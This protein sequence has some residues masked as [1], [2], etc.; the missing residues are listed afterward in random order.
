M[1]NQKQ[2]CY[3]RCLRQVEIM[4][5]RFESRNCMIVRSVSLVVAAATAM[6]LGGVTNAQA[7]E[8]SSSRAP[9]TELFFEDF[10]GNKG[11]DRF[12]WGVYHRNAGWQIIGQPIHSTG[13]ANAFHGGSWTG[14]HNLD[15]GPPSTQ[16][17][18]RSD[19]LSGANF[20]FHLRELVYLCRDH[21]MTS[22]GDVDG[23][24]V[25][26]FS[27][28]QTFDSVG[29]VRFNVNLTDLGPRKWIK[30]GVVSEATYNSLGKGG[31]YD[32]NNA[33]GHVRSEVSA[34]GLSSS[35]QDAGALY[36]AWSGGASAGYPGG[37]KIGSGRARFSVNPTPRNKKLR[38]QVSLKD[39]GNGTVTFTVANAH[40]TDYASFPKCPCR[41]VFYDHNYTPEKSENGP[42]IGFTWHWDNIRVLSAGDQKG[43]DKRASNR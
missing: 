15:C 7:R 26:W 17:P 25:I 6:A 31:V 37:M 38:H 11:L 23:Y 24:S 34:S 33:P 10:A 12:T 43:Q 21:V 20:D 30:V 36:A 35:M 40:V 1:H 3:N 14:D 28:K 19:K 29:E 2:G 41:V 4:T 18:L 27:P 32:E 22:M 16:R 39:N 5:S 9:A 42:P 8:G 13:W